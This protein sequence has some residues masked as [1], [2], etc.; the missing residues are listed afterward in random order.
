VIDEDVEDS[1]DRDYE[2]IADVI[3][4]EDWKIHA[5]PCQLVIKPGGGDAFPSRIESTA[6]FAKSDLFLVNLHVRSG[7]STSELTTVNVCGAAT[8]RQEPSP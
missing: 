1:N 6:W 3:D 7:S 5:Q 8:R 4:E 2:P